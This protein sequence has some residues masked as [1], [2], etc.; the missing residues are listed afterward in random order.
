[1]GGKWLELLKQIAPS[2]TRV[3]V[4]RDASQGGGNSEFAVIQAMAPSLK[5]EI[6]NPVNVATPVRS[7]APLRPSRALR[8]AV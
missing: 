4:L 8:M 7:S 2:V 3:A 5:V 1:M 6:N